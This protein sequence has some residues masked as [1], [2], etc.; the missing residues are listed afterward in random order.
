MSENIY[1]AAR[2]SRREELCGYR[3]QLEM[4]GH[5]VTSRW[6]NG[7]H[8][9][10]DRGTPIG[11]HGEK[12]VEEGGDEAAEL[13]D[14]FATEDV[15]DVRGAKILIAFTEGARS[16]PS[17]GGRHVELG[18][19]LALQ[20]RVLIVG[21]R[22]NLFCWLREVEW[23]PDWKSC[24]ASLMK[25]NALRHPGSAGFQPALGASSP[26]AETGFKAPTAEGD[27]HC[28]VCESARA[29]A[30]KSAPLLKPEEVPY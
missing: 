15:S 14:M 30:A 13:R 19:A 22:E 25:E 11:D 20:K 17:R 1:L 23:F 7:K 26:A 24:L 5:L 21:P 28:A 29:V 18:M 3:Q 4:E 10:S 2:Y 9:I 16:G 27:C 8:Q 6:L 12:L